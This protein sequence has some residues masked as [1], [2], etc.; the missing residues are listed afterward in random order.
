MDTQDPIN[1]VYIGL[2]PFPVMVVNEGLQGSPTKHVKILVVTIPRKGGQPNVYG[3]LA[4][5]VADRL[6]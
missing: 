3:F 6:S 1:G 2:A 5:F 4:L